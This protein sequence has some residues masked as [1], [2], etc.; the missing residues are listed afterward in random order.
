MHDGYD[1]VL[2]VKKRDEVLIFGNSVFPGLKDNV[3]K[4]A[5]ARKGSDLTKH[6]RENAS[7]DRILVTKDIEV[8]EVGM[9]KLVSMN[10]GLLCFF[11]GSGLEEEGTVDY[12]FRNHPWADVWTF[13]TNVGRV[14]VTSAKGAPEWVD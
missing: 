10:R 11:V 4:V 8:S 13:D 5:T 7:Y 9:R 3:F 14:V 12:I 1:E 2:D 6:V